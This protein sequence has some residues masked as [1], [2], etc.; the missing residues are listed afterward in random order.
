MI[1]INEDVNDL[2]FMKPIKGGEKWDLLRPG[3]H[4]FLC[5]TNTLL[6]TDRRE[7]GW[8]FDTE[9]LFD[10][11]NMNCYSV[12]KSLLESFGEVECSASVSRVVNSSKLDLYYNVIEA[13]GSKGQPGKVK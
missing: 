10:N 9:V 7:M 11:S 6:I 5:F 1:A 13:I 3:D 2:W 8:Q 4:I 12:C